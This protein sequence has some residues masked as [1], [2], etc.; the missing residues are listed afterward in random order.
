[1]PIEHIGLGVPDLD[2]VRAHRDGLMPAGAP[3]PGPARQH[4]P[5]RWGN[6]RIG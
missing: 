2:T 1:M 6:A 5:G 3:I 4:D